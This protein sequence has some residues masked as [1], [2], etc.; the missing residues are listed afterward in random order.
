LPAFAFIF[1]AEE[2]VLS[3]FHLFHSIA[4]A[5]GDGLRPEL[6]AFFR[7]RSAQVVDLAGIREPTRIV[8]GPTPLPRV[9]P[10]NVVLFTTAHALVDKEPQPAKRRPRVGRA[11]NLTRKK[12]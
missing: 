5:R 2:L 12:S 10:S 1:D 6:A 9:L 8:S 3:N 7:D 11:R 4:A